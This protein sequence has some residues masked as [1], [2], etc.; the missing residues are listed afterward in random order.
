MDNH[1]QQI[2]KILSDNKQQTE[3]ETDQMV[4][5]MK[6]LI[7]NELQESKKSLL[8]DIRFMVEKLQKEVQEDIKAVQQNFQKSHDGLVKDFSGIK[9]VQQNFQ[10]SH[11]EFVKD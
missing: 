11:D 8:S 10:K 5:T 2:S 4:K 9:A 7:T 3:T 1:T 6:L